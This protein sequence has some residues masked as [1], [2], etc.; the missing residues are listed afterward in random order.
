VASRALPSLFVALAVAGSMSAARDAHAQDSAQLPPV[1]SMDI[2]EREGTPRPAAPDD[3]TGHVYI[4]AVSGLLLPAGFVR[5]DAA[6]TDVM[7]YGLGVGGTLG[8]GISR[9]AEMDV[10]G[11]YGFF[12]APSDCEDCSSDTVAGSLGFTYHLAQGVAL[13][14]WMRLG[15]GYRTMSMDVTNPGSSTPTP[16]RYH[17]VDFLQIGLGATYFPVS[18]F[19]FGPY[20]EA[21]VGTMVSRPSPD[22]GAARVYAMFHLG[23]RFEIDPVRWGQSDTPAA[24][25]KKDPKTTAQTKLEPTA[26]PANP[27]PHPNQ[28]REAEKDATA[29]PSLPAEPSL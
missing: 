26:E 12:A 6:L 11:I 14:P 21:D 1:P 3:R 29:S 4:R 15:A 10:T 25:P 27:A 2:E 23:L 8:V 7:V 18:S 5:K 20:A 9:Y 24:P 28:V 22:P 19:G 16:G 17:G 13:D